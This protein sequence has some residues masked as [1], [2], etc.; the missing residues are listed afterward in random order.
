MDI[1]RKKKGEEKR[2]RIN[3][4]IGK[5]NEEKESKL[6]DLKWKQKNQD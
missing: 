3:R 5:K 1:L 2:R 6:Y 4:A